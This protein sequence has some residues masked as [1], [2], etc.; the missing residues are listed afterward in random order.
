MKKLLKWMG[1]I[2]FGPIVLFIAVLF[3]VPLF[4]DVQQLKPVIE[5]KVTHATGRALRMDGIE[6]RLFP[7]ANLTLT[8]V[9]LGNPAGFSASEFA[10]IG[11][12]EIKVKLFPLLYKDIQVKQVALQ[13]LR[14]F[15]EKR[16]DGKDNWTFA[17]IGRKTPNG[18]AAGGPA[19]DD[20]SGGLPFNALAVGGV[21]IT[22]SRVEFLDSTRG[23]RREVK[24][25]SLSIKD[26][27]LER[28]MM[29]HA[30]G[31]LDEIQMSFKG[32]AGPIGKEPGKNDFPINLHL[33][34]LNALDVHIMGHLTGPLTRPAYDVTV[35]MSDFTSKT[36]AIAL[37]QPFSLVTR[38]TDAL[39]KPSL[40]AKVT[41]SAASAS[42]ADGMLRIDQSMMKF[43][44][45]V[46]EFKKP[47]ISFS[48]HVDQIDLDR[49]LPPK[50]A[51]GEAVQSRPQTAG[52][53]N[54]PPQT[55]FTP[56]RK[57][58]LDGNVRVDQFKAGGV[59]GRDLV[60]SVS[61]EKGIFSI[62]PF[63]MI[64]YEGAVTGKGTWNLQ[65]DTPSGQLEL[66][67]DN[68]RIGPLLK[69][70]AQKDIITGISKVDARLRM[71]GDTP[72]EIK[73]SL[74]GSGRF[75]V[76]EG[77]IKGID[78]QAMARHMRTAFRVDAT[79]EGNPETAFSELQ[80]PFTVTN[81]V[82]GTDNAVLVSPVLRVRADGIADL[83]EER[84]DFRMVPTLS[85]VSGGRSDF[86]VKIGSLTV[87]IRVSGPFS[88]P[89]FRLELSDAVEK[90]IETL[91]PK[92]FELGK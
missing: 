67:A 77:V 33:S 88:K 41:G 31:R 17:G 72:A 13:G 47:Q 19:S 61:G 8:G 82:V 48:C 43:T 56:L 89:V 83:S 7:R 5:K 34:A 70:L 16:A 58:V 84:L 38:D 79:G 40:R 65:Q 86:S 63:S 80:V 90:G 37:G 64:V 46:T 75:S 74:N 6:L 60:I 78:L 44:I 59:N 71:K 3:I 87:P 32:S 76:K 53:E 21:S 50:A 45:Q 51:G 11:A 1:L 91:L 10:T 81:G 35:E 15:L 14:L 92:L 49:Y 2:V 25:I 85:D 68:V 55:D 28:P 26:I 62:N 22:D 42:V 66:S 4:V 57:L 54:T 23:I 39:Q 27:S 18:D 12:F 69:D 36:V 20:D 30:S 52:I 29:F 73:R 24:D 9:R